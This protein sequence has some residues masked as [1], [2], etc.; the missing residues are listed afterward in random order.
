[1]NLEQ[2]GLLTWSDHRQLGE[3]KPVDCIPHVLW[4]AMALLFI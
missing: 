1:M 2:V 3:Q 4:L